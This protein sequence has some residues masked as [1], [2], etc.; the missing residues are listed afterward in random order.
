MVAAASS[1]RHVT[2]SHAV[3]NQFGA[4]VAVGLCAFGPK[5]VS[6]GLFGKIFATWILTLPFAAGIAAGMTAA[7]RLAVN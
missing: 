5:H 2:T 6:F 4:V 3:H 7:L 1:W